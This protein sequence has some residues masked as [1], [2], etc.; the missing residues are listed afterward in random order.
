VVALVVETPSG[1][2]CLTKTKFVEISKSGQWS[3]ILRWLI[4][5]CY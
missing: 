5:V 4:V 3:S 1:T 2:F